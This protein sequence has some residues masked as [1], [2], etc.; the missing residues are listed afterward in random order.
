M[1]KL[2]SAYGIAIIEAVILAVTALSFG[3]DGC[4]SAGMVITSI[5]WSV[6]TYRFYVVLN[7]YG[8]G[9]YFSSGV[10][11]KDFPAYLEMDETAAG[12]KDGTNRKHIRR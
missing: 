3:Y 6:L 2:W 10:P 4:F 7:P 5:F 9:H 11:G 1:Q 8:L 12:W